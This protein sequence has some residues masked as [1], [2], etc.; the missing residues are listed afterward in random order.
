M[1][2][3]IELSNVSKCY[4]LGQFTVG[5]LYDD[6]RESFKSFLK[7]DS[8]A[9][10]KTRSDEAYLRNPEYWALKNVNIAIKK[11][12]VVGLIGANGA[13]KST[14]LK[15][16]SKITTPTEGTIR[17]KGKVASLLEVGTGFHPNLT[18]RENIY[19]NGAILGMSRSETKSKLREIIEFSECE[20][21]I[22]TPI[23]R[24][25][26]GMIVRLG[27]SIAVHLNADILIIDEV[28]AVGDRSFTQK[29]IDK[30]RAIAE[31]GTRTILFVSH[32]LALVREVCNAGIVIEQGNAIQYSTIEESI[33]RYVSMSSE[34]GYSRTFNV[35]KEIPSIKS[36]EIDESMLLAGSIAVRV[37]FD[38]P[39]EFVPYVGVTISDEN[40]IPVYRTDCQMHPL[41]QTPPMVSSGSMRCEIMAPP[42]HEGEYFISVSLG[43]QEANYD[44]KDN[45]L[46][47]DYFP[48]KITLN[49]PEFRFRGCINYPAGWSFEGDEP[50]GLRVN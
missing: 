28:L 47:F 5:T 11:G 40:L 19:L 4:K 17:I 3:S 39:F 21:F 14:V 12:D 27:F 9:S 1:T 29:A 25:S 18:G 37:S 10:E 42:L 30:I 36:L 33:F 34:R 6:I 50:E 48:R 31:D 46:L 22:D 20:E 35:D 41:T 45:A 32:N 16:C 49:K 8:T 38:S 13:G 26:S 44:W 24:Y 2:I 15:L 23:K 43:D 7:K